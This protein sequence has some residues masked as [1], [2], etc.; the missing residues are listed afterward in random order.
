MEELSRDRDVFMAMFIL[1]ANFDL[2][3]A[4]VFCLKMPFSFCHILVI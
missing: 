4:I 3:L 2:G 1:T